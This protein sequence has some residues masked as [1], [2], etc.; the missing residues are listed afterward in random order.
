[1][2]TVTVEYSGSALTPAGF[3]NVKIKAEI[4]LTSAKMGIVK[5]VLAIDGEEPNHGM[6]RTGA[7]RQRYNGL[8]LAEREI[9]KKKRLSTCKKID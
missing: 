6:S 4:E 3:R 1:M 9:G 8:A 2:A 5:R 7:N